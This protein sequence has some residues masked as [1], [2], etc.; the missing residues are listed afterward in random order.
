MLAGP[1]PLEA[2]AQAPAERRHQEARPGPKGGSNKGGWALRAPGGSKN[3]SEM[4]IRS[5]LRTPVG[6]EGLTPPIAAPFGA[7]LTGGVAAAGSPATESDTCAPPQV[8]QPHPATARGTS[9]A[10]HRGG[11]FCQA[12]GPPETPCPES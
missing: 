11:D 12:G 3:L 5:A 6:S 2:A 8:V 7:R 9:A 4:Q 10:A 1:V